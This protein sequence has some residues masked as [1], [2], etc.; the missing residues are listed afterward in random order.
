MAIEEK[1]LG[2]VMP[3][4]VEFVSPS[5]VNPVCIISKRQQY[6][7][8]GFDLYDLRTSSPFL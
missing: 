2:M 4:L 1:A 5:T 3:E 6:N 7:K 8:N